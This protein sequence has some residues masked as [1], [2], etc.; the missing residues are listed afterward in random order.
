MIR[1]PGNDLPALTLAEGARFR[2]LRH[3]TD[4]DKIIKVMKD[5]RHDGLRRHFEVRKAQRQF[6]ECGTLHQKAVRTFEARSDFT[7]V[8][9][10]FG[11]V[12]TPF[13]PGL[14]FEAVRG[15]DRPLGPNLKQIRASGTLED[16]HR[17]EVLALMRRCMTHDVMIPDLHLKNIVWGRARGRT[18]M[19]VIDG[20]DD[21]TY[22][23]RFGW[24]AAFD[25]RKMRSIWH[26]RILRRLDIE[27]T[28]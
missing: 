11:A 12:E 23:R 27:E 13:G 22:F 7:P 2:I 19:F 14:V 24:L 28:A 26:K 5:L 25:R 3:P 9:R 21:H 1:M 16:R 17:R 20:F 6:R 8:P 18:A 10:F 4:G 15:E